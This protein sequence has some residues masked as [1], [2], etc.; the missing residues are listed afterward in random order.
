MPARPAAVLFAV[1]LGA[2]LVVLFTGPWA[3]PAR[4]LTVAH[5]S[6]RYLVLADHLLAHRTM[7]KPD[8]DGLMHRAVERLRAGNGTLPPADARGLTPEHFRTPAY[9]LYLAAFGGTPGLCGALLGQCLLGALAAC[10]L[11]RVAAGLGASPRAALLAGWLWALHPGVVTSDLLP[12]TECLF[13]ALGLG[14]LAL[15]TRSGVGRQVGGGAAIGLAGLVR[16]LGLLYL[17]AA[18]VIGWAVWPRRWRAAAVVVAVAAV[19]SLGWAARNAAVGNGFRVSTVGELNLY[20]YGA[21]YAVSEARG[22]DWLTS[23][24]ARVDELSARLAARLEPGQDV[25]ALA[26][27]EAAAE[28][29]AHPGVALAVAVKSFI[30]LLL[31][32]SVGPA[33]GLYGVEYQPSGFASDLLTG[34]LDTSKLSV[35]AVAVLPWMGLNGL[36]ALGAVVGLVRAGVRRRWGL[37]VGTVATIALFSAAS[38]P[39]GLERFR[40]PMAPF[41]FVLAAS[42]VRPPERAGAAAGSAGAERVTP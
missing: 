20:Y 18:L 42:A 29:R 33:V 36:V 2:R 37:V 34:K 11:V 7:G 31:D 40:L 35:S 38:F 8:E 26:R 12:L 1:A 3:D 22:E 9:P 17:P 32:H 14:G 13:V 28:L 27:R 6:Q 19:P 25:F 30:K 16:P 23:W 15:L 24:P 4:L 10:W 39:V 5:D 41:L 21:G